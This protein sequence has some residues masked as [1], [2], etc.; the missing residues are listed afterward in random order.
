[1]KKEK[2]RSFF[3]THLRYE[4]CEIVLVASSV[5]CVCVCLNEMEM[6]KRD[7]R[8][9]FERERKKTTLFYLSH[10]PVCMWT[11][12]RKQKEFG[13]ARLEKITLASIW[14]QRCSR[15]E[16]GT[17]QTFIRFGRHIKR[18]MTT[19]K[20]WIGYFQATCPRETAAH[21]CE[22]NAILLPF[23]KRKLWN[24]FID[25]VGY[26]V[27]LVVILVDG[28]NNNKKNGA[29]GERACVRVEHSQT[30]SKHVKLSTDSRV[31]SLSAAC[32]SHRFSSYY[33]SQ[34]TAFVVRCDGHRLMQMLIIN[35]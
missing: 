31:I 2:N 14:M 23:L 25:S 34:S 29:M 6:V 9:I 21:C 12:E 1:M 16:Y 18:T 7:H 19:T 5:L 17:H 20:E 26:Y 33:L 32:S 35:V 8:I 15:A 30:D 22:Q 13:C 3:T 11:N 24:V 28:N 27:Y 10:G 4:L